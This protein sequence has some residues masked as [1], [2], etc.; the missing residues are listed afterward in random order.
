MC[1][2]QY[3][4]VL[5]VYI[6][7]HAVMCVCVYGIHEY[8]CILYVYCVY[9]CVLCICMCMYVYMYVCMYVCMC[10]CICMCVMVHVCVHV[11]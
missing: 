10:M 6:S 4:V 8:V 5:C 7:V 11:T 9:V 1:V 2:C 3:C